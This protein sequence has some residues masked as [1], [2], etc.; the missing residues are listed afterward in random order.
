MNVRRPGFQLLSL[1]PATTWDHVNPTYADVPC[2]LPDQLGIYLDV[3][4]PCALVSLFI[5]IFTAVMRTRTSDHD[6][7]FIVKLPDPATNPHQR[8]Q[9]T[10]VCFGRRR[11]LRGL[12]CLFGNKRFRPPSKRGLLRNIL[13]DVIDI[14][15]FPISIFVI[16]NVLISR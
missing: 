8:N 15:I 13:Q 10:V 11:G 12:G 1:F 7:K 4:I 9:T 16:V 2:L 5:V 6:Q 3:Y 14:A